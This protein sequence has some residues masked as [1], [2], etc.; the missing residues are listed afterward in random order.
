MLLFKYS[1]TTTFDN[2]RGNSFLIKK[3]IWLT[4]PLLAGQQKVVSHEGRIQKRV[5]YFR[6]A[7]N[8]IER[9]RFQFAGQSTKS[10]KQSRSQ[11]SSKEL[12]SG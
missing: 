6:E 9:D 2:V 10:L 4:L 5:K 11:E 12:Q 3:I 8:T 7:L 1:S